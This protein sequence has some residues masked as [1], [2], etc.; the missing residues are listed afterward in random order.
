MVKQRHVEAQWVLTRV[1]RINERR[2]PTGILLEKARHMIL[3]ELDL[4]YTWI[5]GY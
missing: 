5:L 2:L 4:A 1:A 3:D